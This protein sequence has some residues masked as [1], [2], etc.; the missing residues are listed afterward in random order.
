[1]NL[2]DPKEEL[3]DYELT[4][5]KLRINYYESAVQALEQTNKQQQQKPSFSTEIHWKKEKQ[6]S[7]FYSLFYSRSNYID[8]NTSE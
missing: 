1:M 5:M 7:N 4:T 3:L 2:V 8:S 6:A